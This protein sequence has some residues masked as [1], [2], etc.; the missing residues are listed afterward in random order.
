MFQIPI[1]PRVEIA[2]L[3]ISLSVMQGV[4]GRTIMF[5][6]QMELLMLLQEE[7]MVVVK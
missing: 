3:S 1:S 7:I 4:V 5:I 6:L 2:E